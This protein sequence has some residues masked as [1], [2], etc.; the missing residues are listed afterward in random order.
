MIPLALAGS[1]PLGYLDASGY[2]HVGDA[3]YEWWIL[4][5]DCWHAPMVSPSL[6][7]R[8]L[9]NTPIVETVI[10]VPGGDVAWRAGVVATGTG[11]SLIVECENRGTIPVAV[12]VARVV[13]EVVVSLDVHP[14]T[15]TNTW[16]GAVVGQHEG[17][18][19][20]AA[21][22][23]LALARQHAQIELGD[24]MLDD[25]LV[26]ARTSLLAHQGALV[27]ARRG[28]ERAVVGAVA[29]GLTWLGYEDEAE[30][31]R[32]AARAKPARKGLPVVGLVDPALVTDPLALL[33]D[34]VA[35]AQTVAAIRALAIADGA[36]A[37]DVLPGFKPDW[38]G[39]SIDVRDLPTNHGHASFT[40]R[41]HGDKPALLWDTPVA[42]TA[43]ALA[44]AWSSAERSGEQLVV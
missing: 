43:H 26:A 42:V 33:A 8:A 7:Q 12:A 38:R 44:P 37:L 22:G 36:K 27:A 29:S 25:A 18:L 2:L 16:R 23:W 14:V 20:N 35:A 13:D 19:A 10:R 40:V 9:D 28:A 39:R 30:A 24:P 32:L 5:D 34:P 3:R 6:R 17:E 1:A 31:L 11:E 15:H 4:G 21:K 41:W